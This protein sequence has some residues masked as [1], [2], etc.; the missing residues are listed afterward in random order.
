MDL[1][2]KVRQYDVVICLGSDERLKLLQGILDG[3]IIS[4]EIGIS[5]ITEDKWV[6]PKVIK[7]VL[8]SIKSAR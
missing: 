7:K 6:D 2:G 5:P 1:A 8:R 3:E 4:I